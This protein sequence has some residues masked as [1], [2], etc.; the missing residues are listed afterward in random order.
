ML[1][2]VVVQFDSAAALDEAP[3]ILRSH[4]SEDRH[5]GKPIELVFLVSY[6]VTDLYHCLVPLV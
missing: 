6:L 5:H 3:D 2:I 4:W 1:G